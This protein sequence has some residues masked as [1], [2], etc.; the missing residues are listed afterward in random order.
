[1]VVLDAVLLV[2]GDRGGKLEARGMAQ[3]GARSVL[4]CFVIVLSEA[5]RSVL[6]DAMI[7]VVA[8]F[9]FLLF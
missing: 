8:V 3:Y 5:R 4:F 9:C 2:V 7:V 6:L 1:V